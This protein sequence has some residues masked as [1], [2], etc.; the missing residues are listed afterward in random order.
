MASDHHLLLGN[1]RIK[2]KKYVDSANRLQQQYNVHKLKSREIKLQFNRAV[3]NKVEALEDMTEDST[4]IVW[5]TLQET[6]KE[7]CEEV[8]GTRERKHK[9]VAINSNMDADQRKEPNGQSMQ[10]S[11]RETRT[12]N[13]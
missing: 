12:P 1:V 9:G 5:A 11:R 6:W 13:N 2:L 3:R 4:D 7:A 10:D 8:L